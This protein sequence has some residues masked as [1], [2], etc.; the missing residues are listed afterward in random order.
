LGI[1]PF[2]RPFHFK[3]THIDTAKVNAIVIRIYETSVTSYGRILRNLGSPTRKQ[4]RKGNIT[5]A[6]TITN[7]DI[8]REGARLV[9]QPD[10]LV[11]YTDFADSTAFMKSLI[12][13]KPST[14]YFIE[15][16]TY[17]KL[18]ISA[19]EKRMLA[20]RIS[21][22]VIVSGLINKFAYQNIANP[23]TVFDSLDL[24]SDSINVAVARIVK[25]T[26]PAYTFHEIDLSNKLGDIFIDLANINSSIEGIEQAFSRDSNTVKA[27]IP[28]YKTDLK[29]FKQLLLRTDWFNIDNQT[30]SYKAIQ[31]LIGAL[32]A[33]FNALTNTFATPEMLDLIK[34]DIDRSI[35]HKKKVL[36]TLINQTL[37]N[38]VSKGK[39]LTTTY[40]K[41]F[42]K[43]ANEFIRSDLGLAY[44][45]G[46]GRVNPY[47]AAQISL[48]PLNDSIPLREYKSVG[49]VLRSRLSFMIGM[50]VDAIAKDSVRNGLIGRQ[51][52]ILGAGFKLWQWLKFNS[53]FYLYYTQP[54]NPMIARDRLSLKGSPFISLSID[55]RVQSLLNGIGTA[56]FKTQT[57]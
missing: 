28:T 52:L 46:I 23:E 40:P 12:T 45:W 53:G 39:A 25:A 30:S 18:P 5:K 42:V 35:N 32:R 27:L 44:V 6:I 33:K 21:G 50:S 54:K 37:V 55:I 11:K 43:Q 8:I 36:D 41:E 16:S 13:L 20:A 9:I 15:I 38:R 22:S 14:G 24:M 1:L 31:D 51:A 2:D 56:I 49:N 4:M 17:E 3:F 29:N 48:S 57:P 10:S 19:S 7:Q 34:G 26:N 47:V